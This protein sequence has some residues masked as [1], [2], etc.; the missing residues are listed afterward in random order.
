MKKNILLL[1]ALAALGAKA[2]N[3]GKVQ[4]YTDSYVTRNWFGLGVHYNPYVS[5]RRVAS[6]FATTDAATF[7][8]INEGADALYGQSAGIDVYFDFSDRFEIVSGGTWVQGGW[9]YD[10]VRFLGGFEGVNIDT[11]NLY[12]M[13]VRYET[14]NIPL[15]FVIKTQITDIWQLEV[16]PAIELAFLGRYDVTVFDND[17]VEETI[18]LKPYSR[19]TNINIG[20]YLGGSWWLTDQM[21]FVVRGHFRYALQPYMQED[22]FF[23]EVPYLAGLNLGARYQF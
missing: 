22:V 5:D 11:I 14:F 8:A 4:Y 10:V 20:L 7:T 21:A 17:G 12:E 6:G 13:D 19:A 2:Q 9:N 1:V 23:R 16:A 3:G 18:D 15:Q